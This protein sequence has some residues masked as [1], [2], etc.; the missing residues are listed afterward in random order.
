ML[1]ININNDFILK[2][3]KIYT[4][5]DNIFFHKQIIFFIVFEIEMM[6]SHLF[7]IN[8]ENRIILLQFFYN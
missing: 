4:K 8:C 3:L 1:I 7:S 5:K 2:I 6:I